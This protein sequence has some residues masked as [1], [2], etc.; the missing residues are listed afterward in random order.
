MEFIAKSQKRKKIKINNKS[1]K[2]LFLGC[3]ESTKKKYKLYNVQI[4]SM[5]INRYVVFN[6][7]INEIEGDNDSIFSI[8]QQTLKDET[9]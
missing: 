3:D 2:N 9:H 7:G 4:K 5:F 1:I 6:E 8:R